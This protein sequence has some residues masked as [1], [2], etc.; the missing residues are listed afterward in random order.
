MMENQI[1]ARI[2]LAYEDYS[3]KPFGY[4]NCFS[5]LK[6]LNAKR[7]DYDTT[8]SFITIGDTIHFEDRQYI[9][10]RIVPAIFE[11]TYTGVSDL[12]GSGLYS[13]NFQVALIVNDK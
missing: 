5:D 10:K 4:I 8:R 3:D 6:V 11:R 2:V 1:L 7:D 9:V 13:I 12:S